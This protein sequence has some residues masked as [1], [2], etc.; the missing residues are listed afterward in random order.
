LEPFNV[1]IHAALQDFHR[2]LAR[3]LD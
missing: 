3:K 2:Y 1:Q